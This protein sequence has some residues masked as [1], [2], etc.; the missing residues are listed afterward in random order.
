MRDVPFQ[1]AVFVPELLAEHRRE[2]GTRALG[3][4]KQGVS[5]LTFSP[6]GAVLV[7]T[8]GPRL[9]AWDVGGGREVAQTCERRGRR[10]RLGVA[11]ERFDRSFGGRCTSGSFSRR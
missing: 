5:K 8:A 2:I 3:G 9:R 11:Q 4:W 6:V 1:L 7:G 10:P